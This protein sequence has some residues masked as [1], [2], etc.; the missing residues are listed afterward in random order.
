LREVVSPPLLALKLFRPP[1]K[2]LRN[3]GSPF[4]KL[5]SHDLSILPLFSSFL[6]VGI[7]SSLGRGKGLLARLPFPSLF[8]GKRVGILFGNVLFLLLMRVFFPP[9]PQLVLVRTAREVFFLYRG[10][11]SFFSKRGGPKI[12]F[13]GQGPPSFILRFLPPSVGENENRSAPF[14]DEKVFHSPLCV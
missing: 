9:F 6:R 8:P 13:P 2:N 4:S 10:A 14:S 1:E 3:E 11:L 7:S 12:D 5:S